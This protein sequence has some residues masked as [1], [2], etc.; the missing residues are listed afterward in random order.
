[1]N[2]QEWL[3]QIILGLLINSGEEGVVNDRVIFK[4]IENE[5]EKVKR[6]IQLHEQFYQS[7]G[8]DSGFDLRQFNSAQDIEYL[9]Q[10]YP[11]FNVL[12][13]IDTILGWLWTSKHALHLTNEAETWSLEQVIKQE[14]Q[15]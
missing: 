3:C 15:H 13:T 14:F 6:L 7:I 5:F 11:A 2:D 9:I 10:D 4:F 8:G 1:M 12:A